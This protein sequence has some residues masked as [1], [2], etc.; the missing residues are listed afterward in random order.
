MNILD[1][2][3]TIEPCQ[4]NWNE[5][6]VMPEDHIKYIIDV[7]T[8]VPTKQNKN[9]YSLLAITDRNI[10]D[11][12]FEHAI[13]PGDPNTYR[14]NTQVRANLL[15]IWSQERVNETQKDILLSIGI[16]G[17]AAALAGAELGYKTGFCCCYENK[18]IGSILKKAKIKPTGF[19]DL[20]LGIGMPNEDYDPRQCV[21][22]GQVGALKESKGNKSINV[23][24]R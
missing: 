17:S 21:I 7:C 11:Q 4:R 14:Q 8:T 15:L 22:D 16:S 10:I 18:A 23:R 19:I 3:K 13:L 6:Y 5:N 12:I 1:Y 2:A 9:Y 20:M 24:F